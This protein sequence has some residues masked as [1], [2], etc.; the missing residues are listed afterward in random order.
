MRAKDG[1]CGQHH[2]TEGG[3]RQRALPPEVRSRPEA[4]TEEDVRA[5]SGDQGAAAQT[6]VKKRS[7][8]E[9]LM[10]TRQALLLQNVQQSVN[11]SIPGACFDRPKVFPREGKQA[12]EGDRSGERLVH[13]HR[14][15]KDHWPEPLGRHGQAD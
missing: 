5:V 4:A 14:E 10:A 11:N 7:R 12:N 2:N 3:H 13:Q 6:V 9:G 1:C 8:K 15:A